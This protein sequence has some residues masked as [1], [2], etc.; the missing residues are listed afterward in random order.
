MARQLPEHLRVPWAIKDALLVFLAAWIVLPIVVVLLV[1]LAA[2]YDPLSAWFLDGLR[3]GQIEA[4][5][6]LTV[7]DALGAVA[8]LALYLRRYRASWAAVGW[9]RFSVWQA[10]GYMLGMF[11]AFA[12]LS[13][14]ALWLV[15]LL[16][17][18][19]NANQPQTNDFL[20]AAQS[21]R[22]LALAALV[23]LPPVIEETVFR[24]FIFPAVAKHWG[25]VAGAVVSSILFGLAH[26]Q[27]NVS[28]YT[29]VLGLV[30]CFLYV[31]LRSIVPGILLHMLN[32]Y[33]A[34]MALSA[35]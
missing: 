1:R 22:G 19:F 20:N 9:R 27:A 32:N 16:D 10:S 5:F 23:L 3:A 29:F 33:L 24:G 15:S 17:P 2:P 12:V 11:I 6:A 35:R 13:N 14:A 31:R 26:L 4:S 34:F 8:I 30:L 7:V 25:L 21:H 28:V 18:N